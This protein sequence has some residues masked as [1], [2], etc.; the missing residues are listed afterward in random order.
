MHL[1]GKLRF[2]EGLGHAKDYIEMQW[3]M[4]QQDTPDDFV[5]ATGIQA[6]VRE[7]IELTALELGWGGIEW[8]NTGIDEIG[9][10]KDTGDIIIRID[11][12]YFRPTEVET[13]LGDPAKAQAVLGWKPRITLQQLIS[14]MV[15][16]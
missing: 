6:S 14:E 16:K 7:F 15:Q 11:P 5:I 2:P 12:R 13:L 3:L 10:R 9:K 1:H 4:L 8:E